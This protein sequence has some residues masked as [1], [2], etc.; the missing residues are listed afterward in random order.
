MHVPRERLAMFDQAI[1]DIGR[2]G[3]LYRISIE[4]GQGLTI[5]EP[6]GHTETMFTVD[7][8]LAWA[9]PVDS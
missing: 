6:N 2:D 9:K 7:G 8:H 4:P 3:P 5:T 1:D